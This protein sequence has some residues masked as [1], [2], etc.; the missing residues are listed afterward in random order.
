[1][2]NFDTPIE[3]RG[4]GA[5][6]WDTLPRTAGKK[7]I[8]P[9]WVADMDFAVAPAIAE[10]LRRRVEHPVF[11]YTDSSPSFF[12][13]LLAWYGERYGFTPDRESV[14]LGPGLLP[15]LG[16]AVRLLSEKGDGVLIPS[17]V[18]GPFYKVTETNGRVPVS[19]PL[20]RDPE[21]RFSLSIA[22]LRRAVAD[23]RSKGLSLPLLILCSPHNPGG[24]VWRRE[25]LQAL[26]DFTRQEGIALIVDE[27]HGDFIYPPRR[28]VSMAALCAPEDRVVVLSSANKTFNIAALHLSHCLIP[29]AQLRRQVQAI[30]SAEG[31]GHP[32]VLSIAAAE[33]AY[34]HGAPWLDELLVYLYANIEYAVA[35]INREIPGVRAFT[36]EGT[37]LIWADAAELIRRKGL[38]DDTDLLDRLEN[39]AR[40]KLTGGSFFGQLGV[41]NL[42][43]NVACPRAQLREGLERLAAWASGA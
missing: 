13:A 29:Q 7:D 41:G 4:T 20:E 18:Y 5:L 23:G 3:R 35:F 15:S 16:I 33:A 26:L 40:V 32:N 34:A 39:E 1:V 43:I 31:F 10:T 36:P 11:G 30:L 38:R 28:F 12:E 2:V 19:V 17:P 25:E 22:A 9:L 37:Y 27:I 14:V 8:I 6:K 24:T 42:R 21:G